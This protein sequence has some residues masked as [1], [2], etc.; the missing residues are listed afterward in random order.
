MDDGFDILKGFIVLENGR[1][2]MMKTI[3]DIEGLLERLTRLQNILRHQNSARSRKLKDDIDHLVR[4]V[5]SMGTVV[6]TRELSKA[7]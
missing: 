5:I 4:I 1:I 2:N 7:Q 6:Y 3:R